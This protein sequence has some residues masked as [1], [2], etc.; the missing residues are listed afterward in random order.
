MTRMSTALCLLLLS[1]VVGAAPSRG[2]SEEQKQ[3]FARMAALGRLGQ[4]QDVADVV[5]LLAGDD[6]RWITEQNVCANGGLI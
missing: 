2:K 1:P 5:A 3:S 6:A 4:T